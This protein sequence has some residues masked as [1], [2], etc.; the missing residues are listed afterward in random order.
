[1]CQDCSAIEFKEASHKGVFQNIFFRIVTVEEGDE[2]NWLVG[3]VIHR[4]N[5]SVQRLVISMAD[6]AKS[7]VVAALTLV[8]LGRAMVDRATGAASANRLWSESSAGN[9]APS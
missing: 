6:Q 2:S 7:E 8:R 5:Q 1:M 3:K 4:V 9:P